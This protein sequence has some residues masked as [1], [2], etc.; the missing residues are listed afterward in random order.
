MEPA[1]LP[2]LPPAAVELVAAHLARD[3]ATNSQ[4][5]DPRR[6]ALP[7]VCR[8]WRRALE[9]APELHATMCIADD[10][11][12]RPTPGG[13]A[14]AY[15][16]LAAERMLSWVRARAE[17]VR[18]LSVDISWRHERCAA[19]DLVAALRG[20]LAAVAPRVEVLRL[21]VDGAPMAAARAW[22][23]LFK[24]PARDGAVSPRL[25]ELRLVLDGRGAASEARASIQGAD[26]LA[27]AA[28][29]PSLQRLLVVAR[30]VKL[31]ALPPALA[32]APAIREVD[33]EFARGG[34]PRL[35]AK[36]AGA[37]PLPPALRR[38]HLVRCP[39]LLQDVL[40]RLPPG[41]EELEAVEDE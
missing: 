27:A 18:D 34:G 14:V 29:C 7:F 37:L 20:V 28:R 12:W 6:H 16:P 35:P 26:A 41:L 17:H 30:G 33:L 4:P 36:H 38:L 13:D 10:D 23:E 3:F 40:E 21:A 5:R 19:A 15:F 32:R 22:T 9:L 1:P 8:A 31:P 2:H 24:T 39:L 25:R 11:L